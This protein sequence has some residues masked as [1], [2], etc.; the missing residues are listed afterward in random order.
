MV[1]TPPPSS[2]SAG[3][4][5]T[6]VVSA[7]D[8]Y[9]N[10]VT[11]FSGEVTIS[12]PG[13]PDFE[14]VTASDGAATFSGLALDAAASGGS[15]RATSPGLASQV[16]P[17]SIVSHPTPTIT[18][19]HVLMSRKTDKKGKPVGR[20]VLQ[21]FVLDFSTAMNPAT[22]GS[23][24]NYTVAALPIRRGRKK[25]AP[26]L[27]PVAFTASYDPVKHS[28]TLNIPARPTFAKG[29]EITVIYSPPN[30]VSSVDGVPLDRND[31]EFTILPRAA[32]LA[33]G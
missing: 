20:A 7:E 4:P 32:G 11:S 18:D 10:V 30:G 9:G 19:E 1:T 14:T 22:A 2:L 33:P 5:F 8:P 21:G 16:T 3:Q 6:I 23:A 28:I 31:A 17:V 27:I 24:A 13:H 15:I 29:G 26:T 12:L 25:S